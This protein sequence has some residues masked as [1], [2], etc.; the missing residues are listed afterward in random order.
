MICRDL[1]RGEQARREIEEATG[2]P[3]VELEI[4]D[5]SLLSSVRQLATRLLER[6]LPVHAL[7]NNA[8]VLLNVKEETSEGLDRTLLTNYLGPFLLTDLLTPLLLIA[9]QQS[10]EPSRVV[11]VSSGGMY[12]QSLEAFVDDFQFERMGR[13]DGSAAYSRTKR[14]QVCLAETQALQHPH[15]DA[16]AFFS[17]HPGWADSPGLHSSLPAFRD[18]L[19]ASL[20]SLDQGAD[21]IVWLA[22]SPQVGLGHSGCFF[23][24]RVVVPQHLWLAGT[25]AGCTDASHARL[26]HL[27]TDLIHTLSHGELTHEMAS[28]GSS[29]P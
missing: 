14:A 7:V 11:H 15:R 26:L 1:G 6:N 21:T 24:D 8:G 25:A 13:W 3:R 28:Q 17:C 20:R 4:A 19:Q 9:Q 12:T 5:V 22:V 29:T 27:S 16:I 2:N 23:E 18:R 10:G